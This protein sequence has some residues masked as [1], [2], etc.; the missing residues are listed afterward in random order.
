MK[1]PEYQNF[2]R[3][4]KYSNPPICLYSIINT[5]PQISPKCSNLWRAVRINRGR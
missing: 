5:S 4:N 3:A 2:A 1:T